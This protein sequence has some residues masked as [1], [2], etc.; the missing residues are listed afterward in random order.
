MKHS[1]RKTFVRQ[2]LADARRLVEEGGLVN[3]NPL[4]KIIV[5]P[6]ALLLG[7]CAPL[8]AQGIPQSTPASPT[9]T[10]PSDPA[11]MARDALVWLAD[12]IQINTSNPPG[13]EQLAADW[14]C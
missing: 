11:P 5:G 6:A 9:T 7:A 14:T 3:W 1:G 2:V 10:A 12:L 8:A 13:N 4:V